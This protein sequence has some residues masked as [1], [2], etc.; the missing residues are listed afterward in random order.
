M[1]HAKKYFLIEPSRYE[2]L[3]NCNRDKEQH[4]PIQN[5]STSDVLVHPS[6]KS[7]STLDKEMS[8]ILTDTSQND[9]DKAQRYAS[10]LDS[11]L[12]NIHSALT[13]TA[14]ESIIGDQK[15]QT[16][17]QSMDAAKNPHEWSIE[18]LVSTVPKTYQLKAADL[19]KFMINNG[20]D[21]NE[22]GVVKADGKVISGSNITELLHDAVRQKK[23]VSNQSTY[24]AFSDALSA[25]GRRISPYNRSLTSKSYQSFIPQPS[26]NRR[27]QQ[28][29]NSA[30]QWEELNM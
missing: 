17:G 21:W 9:Y 26:R 3:L 1:K 19:L 11:Y 4:K 5:N 7:I 15:I 18:N 10:K 29:A 25:K 20:F 24:R 27:L 8:S 23:P 12:R 2:E 22:K 13:K 28:I 16:E 14:K 30:Q 6:I